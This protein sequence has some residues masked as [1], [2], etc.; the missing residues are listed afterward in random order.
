L[1][2][3]AKKARWQVWTRLGAGGKDADRW[4]RRVSVV[5][6]EDETLLPRSRTL[7]IV[8]RRVAVCPRLVDIKREV[9]AE[10]SKCVGPT[11]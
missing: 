7:G 3:S 5:P 1:A 6:G 11:S 2:K 10:A 9:L 8:F 4:W